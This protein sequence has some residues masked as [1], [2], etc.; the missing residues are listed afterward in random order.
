[1][2]ISE[3]QVVK[4]AVRVSSGYKDIWEKKRRRD[5]DAHWNEIIQAFDSQWDIWSKEGRK[6]RN[7]LHKRIAKKLRQPFRRKSRGPL[8]AKAA[9]KNNVRPSRR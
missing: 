8:R 5:G 9:G 4:R 6:A 7:R 2:P 3:S 1:M